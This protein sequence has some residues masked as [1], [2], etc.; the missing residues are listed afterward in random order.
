MGQKGHSLIY[1]EF[2][3]AMKDRFLDYV[4]D[5]LWV[6]YRDRPGLA[7]KWNK[8]LIHPL[9]FD[10]ACYLWLALDFVESC[11]IISTT[12]DSW[13]TWEVFNPSGPICIWL[14]TWGKTLLLRFCLFL[15]ARPGHR[16]AIHWEWQIFCLNEVRPISSLNIKHWQL[17]YRQANACL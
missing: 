3:A 6:E 12:E 10:L 1:I 17:Y 9:P 2:E 11:R 5:P 7:H 4:L 13:R 16:G 14:E 8:P 15:N